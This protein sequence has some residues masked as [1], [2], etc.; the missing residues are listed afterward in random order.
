MELDD[1]GHG[2]L[3]YTES[4]W[5]VA[6]EGRWQRPPSCTLTERELGLPGGALLATALQQ[7]RIVPCVSV[8]ISLMSASKSWAKYV[9]DRVGPV[10]CG[11]LGVAP[12]LPLRSLQLLQHAFIYD[13]FEG[14][15]SECL[16]RWHRW[17]SMEEEEHR[18][19]IGGGLSSLQLT[20]W[21]P[22]TLEHF[23]RGVQR[24]FRPCMPRRLSVRLRVD[25]PE[26]G[27]ACP[28]E[29][30]AF[31]GGAVAYVVLGDSTQTLQCGSRF[32]H[33]ALFMYAITSDAS[34]LKLQ[35]CEGR[36]ASLTVTLGPHK[37]GAW[38]RITIALDWSCKRLKVSI[39]GDEVGDLSFRNTQ[40][41]HVEHI[42]LANFGGPA[43][44]SWSEVALSV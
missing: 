10:A 36:R 7:S 41:C 5:R 6:W 31:H 13:N 27:A 19:R 40:C 34:A 17:G 29:R 8:L 35:W 15:E 43:V 33:E 14:S 11:N 37:Y 12:M 4:K 1:G 9:R 42:T 3:A 25:R 32:G 44:A 22:D 18:R 38:L 28:E 23:G 16:Q 39:D 30:A 26:E 24:R 20:R 2:S 21:H